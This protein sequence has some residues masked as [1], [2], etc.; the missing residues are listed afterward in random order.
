MQGRIVFVCAHETLRHILFT[1]DVLSKSENSRNC[2]TTETAKHP[3]FNLMF[4]DLH[5]YE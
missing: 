4:K 5:H 2:L 1:L 3:L